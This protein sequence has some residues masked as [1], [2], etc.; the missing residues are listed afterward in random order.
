MC[1]SDKGMERAD[2]ACKDPEDCMCVARGAHMAASTSAT[3]DVVKS[4]AEHENVAVLVQP[5]EQLCNCDEQGGMQDCNS[6]SNCKYDETAAKCMETTTPKVLELQTGA[7]NVKELKIVPHYFLRRLPDGSGADVHEHGHAGHVSSQTF[8]EEYSRVA[9]VLQ[10]R[11]DVLAKKIEE[12][13]K[14]IEKVSCDVTKHMDPATESE[15]QSDGMAVAQFM[16]LKKECSLMQGTAS[17]TMAPSFD[18]AA[19]LHCVKSEADPTKCGTLN[20]YTA[21]EKFNRNLGTLIGKLE[22]CAE[23]APD[24]AEALEMKEAAAKAE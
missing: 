3:E 16:Q 20:C 1:F 24:K 10:E 21:D 7:D 11:L 12:M 5:P 13:S 18:G 15:V 8:A 23:A 17:K 19:D 4:G 9:P 14:D 22:E 6:C 2:D